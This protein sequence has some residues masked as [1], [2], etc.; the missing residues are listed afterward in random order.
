MRVFQLMNTVSKNDDEVVGG[1]G[2][3]H[4]K[5]RGQEDDGVAVSGGLIGIDV[6]VV[7][8]IVSWSRAN[9]P[10]VLTAVRPSGNALGFWFIDD[11]FC[12]QWSKRS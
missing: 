1:G 6:D 2:R 8:L 12:A 4:S 9:V 10:T 5:F 3:W 11:D 7:I